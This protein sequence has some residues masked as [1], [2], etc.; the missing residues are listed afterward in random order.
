MSFEAE[1]LGLS[2]RRGAEAVVGKDGL[3]AACAP[4]GAIPQLPAERCEC[5]HTVEEDVQGGHSQAGTAAGR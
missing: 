1:G 5:R 4:S 2:K 3:Q